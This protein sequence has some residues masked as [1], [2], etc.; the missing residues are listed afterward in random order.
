MSKVRS[1]ELDTGLL[2]NDNPMGVEIDIAVS[3]PREVRVF[4]A[5]EE[6][7]GLDDEMLSRFR[8]RF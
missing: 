4:Q 2:S 3:V 1:S 5:L 7:C 6:V 8:D